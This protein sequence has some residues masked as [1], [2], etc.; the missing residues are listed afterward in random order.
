LSKH[1]EAIPFVAHSA[2]IKAS[3]AK[4]NFWFTIIFLIYVSD[5]IDR[6][7]VNALI[8]SIKQEFGLTDA[9]VGLMPGL[10]YVGLGLLAL[11]AGM[12]VDRFSR[13][14][15]IVLM[16]TAWSAATWA[17]GLTHSFA[18]LMLARLGV[19]FGEAGYNPAGYALIG[20]WYPQRL[21]GAMIGIF[22]IAQPL[23]GGLGMVLAAW[24]TVHYGWR[25]VFG[26]MAIPG[27]ILAFLMLFSPDYKTVKVDEHGVHEVKAG[28]KETLWFIFTNRTLLL[29]YLAQ[30]P[31]VFYIVASSVWGITFFMRSFHLSE[32][33][34]AGP[35]LIVTIFAALGPPITGW[36]SDR[37][38][39]G[40][41]SGRISVALVLIFGILIFH[42]VSYFG[43]LA[44]IPLVA[45]LVAASLGQFCCA[46]QWGTLVAAGLDLVPPHYRGTCQGFLPVFQSL[47][48]CIAGAAT[49]YMSDRIGN[50]FGEDLGLAVALE[51]T[52]VVGVCLS[53]AILWFAKKT[54][55][56][57]YERQKLLGEFAV[58]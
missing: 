5:W 11:P 56:A 4:T 58:E 47:S 39:R 28:A 3:N 32:M 2:T 31:V 49:G 55:Q 9:Q 42:S 40:N 51:I 48:S 45:S 22:N 26:F 12:I 17:T 1:A 30:L 43:A 35:A 15:M 50:R 38:T 19:G 57:D 54:Y 53:F 44:H 37:R 52:L 41:P 14:Y 25:S 24:L 18:G 34:S 27:F 13:K 21:R 7:M 10:L 46:G 29:I 36:W 33:K 23:G 20:A 8:P 16:T 6:S